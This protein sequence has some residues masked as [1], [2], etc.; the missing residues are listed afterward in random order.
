VSEGEEERKMLILGQ[1][2][3]RIR[4]LTRVTEE[5]YGNLTLW[6]QDFIVYFSLLRALSGSY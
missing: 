6:K 5:K 1:T 2:G 3:G 4:T